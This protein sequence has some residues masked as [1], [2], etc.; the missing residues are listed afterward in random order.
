MRAPRA[1]AGDRERLWIMRL[2]S[3]ARRLSERNPNARQAILGSQVR[4]PPNHEPEGQPSPCPQW[5]KHG[6]LDD[7]PAALETILTVTPPWLSFYRRRV[8]AL[9][10]PFLL[11]AHP[12]R[13][14]RGRAGGN[15]ARISPRMKADSRETPDAS[16]PLHH[17]GTCGRLA[18]QHERPDPSGRSCPPRSIAISGHPEFSMGDVTKGR[19]VPPPASAHAD[20]MCAPLSRV[21]RTEPSG[22]GLTYPSSPPDPSNRASSPGSCPRCSKAR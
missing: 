20:G 1:A 17:R 9:G 8:L 11:D 7:A 4:T 5:G 6:P 12:A 14:T 16:S 22:D 21:V 18:S 19:V 2:C 3:V 15:T 13:E 10:Y